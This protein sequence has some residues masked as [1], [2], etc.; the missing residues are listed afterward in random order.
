MYQVKK[1]LKDPL[2]QRDKP[3]C[4]V[5]C[6]KTSYSSYYSILKAN[7]EIL[8]EAKRYIANDSNTDNSKSEVEAKALTLIK[9]IL[10]KIELL[11]KEINKV[12]IEIRLEVKKYR[13]K[14]RIK[15]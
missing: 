15:K 12:I 13:G 11:K 4:L 8:G 6:T 2:Y 3:L 10:K 9:R 1:I 14:E 5:L 7:E